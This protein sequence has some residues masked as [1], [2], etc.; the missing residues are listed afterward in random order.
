[1]LLGSTRHIAMKTEDTSTPYTD[2]VLVGGVKYDKNSNSNRQ[3]GTNRSYYSNLPFTIREVK[4]INEILNAEQPEIKVKLV[5]DTSATEASIRQLEKLNVNLIHL[6]THGYYSSGTSSIS[7]NLLYELYSSTDLNPMVRSGIILAGA[8]NYS[9]TN[10]DNNGFLS[11]MEIAR[12]NFNKLDLVVLSA[13][14]TGLGESMGSEGVF[15]LQRAFKLAGA[16]SIIMSLWKVP[17]EQTAELMKYFY[18]NYM[19]GM[20]KSQALKKAQQMM[21]NKN[22]DPFAWGGFILLER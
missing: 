4:D 6:A 20:T 3:A 16:K 18:S 2:A 17:D 1:M 12:M 21:K 19:G 22:N 10:A 13:C 9:T 14:E 5:T 7:A 11:A 8:N 15:G